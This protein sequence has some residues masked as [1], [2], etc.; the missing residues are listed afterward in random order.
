MANQ[1]VIE[2]AIGYLHDNGADDLSVRQLAILFTLR[3]GHTTVRE[4]SE[5][6]SLHKPAITRTID[7]FVERQ[8]VERNDDPD[9][10]RSVLMALTVTGKKFL[11]R[12]E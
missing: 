5:V 11:S 9:D 7:K 12:F 10:G 6:L 2:E 1:Y 3:A 8:W 4:I